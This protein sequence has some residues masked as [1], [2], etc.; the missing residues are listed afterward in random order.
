MSAGTLP[1]RLI[2]FVRRKDRP[3]C[4]MVPGAGGG[5]GPYLRLASYLGGTH[6]VYAVRSTGLLPDEE[7]EES[8]PGMAE[9][10]LATLD[11]AGIVP[12]LVFGW[13]Q[14]G[15]VAWEVCADLAARGSTP[16]LVVVDSSPEPWPS[17]VER[18]GA[19]RDVIVA[20]LGARPAQDTV[21]RLVRTFEAHVRALSAHRVER[22][23]DGR[24]LLLLCADEGVPPEE[25]ARWHEL[26]RHLERGTLRASHFEVFDPEHLPELTAA[27]GAFLGREEEVTR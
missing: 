19:I 2:P 3:V 8:I 1:G 9:T 7:P 10:V 18:D 27:I 26:A 6:N 17:T 21:D 15:V 12:D 4:V 11:D 24:V 16:D 25:A 20:Q 14:G 5:L 13:S 23:Y 22:P